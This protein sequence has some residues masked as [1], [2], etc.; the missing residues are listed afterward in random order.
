MNFLVI[1]VFAFPGMLPVHVDRFE[2][3]RECQ[4]AQGDWIKS[5]RTDLRPFIS[6]QQES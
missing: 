4:E 6:C 5:Y 3:M 1:L 2:S